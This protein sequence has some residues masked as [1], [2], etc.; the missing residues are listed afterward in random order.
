MLDSDSYQSEPTLFTI[1][2]IPMSSAPHN[3]FQGGMVDSGIM[4]TP[5]VISGIPFVVPI[6]LGL[7]GPLST[8]HT[9]AS[10]LP[11]RGVPSATTMVHTVPSFKSWGH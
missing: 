5:L 6:G 9:A 7:S 4:T 10:T 3:P 2:S 1:Q 8:T 11:T